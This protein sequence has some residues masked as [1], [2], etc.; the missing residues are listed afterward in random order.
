[1]IYLKK[2]KKM[3]SNINLIELK[4]LGHL[5]RIED[6]GLFY[7]ELGKVLQN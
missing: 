2:S 5:L 4:G 3:N 6:V 7:S 1:M